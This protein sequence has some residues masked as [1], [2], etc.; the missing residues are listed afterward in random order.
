MPVIHVYSRPGCHLCE[1]L[2]EELLPLL[3]GRIDLEVRNIDSND[4]WR[5]EYDIRIP[6]VEYEG[7][8]ICEY[9]LDRASIEQLVASVP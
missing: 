9:E 2:I 1:V 7:R 4:A 5:F 3:H 8:V 6:V